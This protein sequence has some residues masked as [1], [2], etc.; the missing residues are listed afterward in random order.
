MKKYLLIVCG[1]VCLLSAAWGAEEGAGRG[2]FP[3]SEYVIVQ[4][5]TAQVEEIESL[6]RVTLDKDQLTQLRQLAPNFPKR[7]GVAS[8]FVEEIADSRFSPWPDQITGIWFCKEA[9]AIPRASLQGSEGCREFPKLLNAGDAVLIDTKGGYG[10]GP[11]NVSREKLAATLAKLGRK[12]PD[13]KNFRIYVLRPPVLDNAQEE[14]AVQRS[15]ADLAKLC[16]ENGI[17]CRIG[18]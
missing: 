14:Q 7:I 1:F 18:G 11:R 12:E 9:V 15:I 2:G 8:P 10:I 17:D 5:T 6:R 3:E 16:R 4:M 13:G